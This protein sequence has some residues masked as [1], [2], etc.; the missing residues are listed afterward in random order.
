MKNIGVSLFSFLKLISEKQKL[1]HF[2][3]KIGKGF[4]HKN[5][6]YIHHSLLQEHEHAFFILHREQL[7]MM[8][9]FII[10]LEFALFFNLHRTITFFLGSIICIYFFDLLFNLFLVIRS[11]A[12]TPEIEV[13]QQEINEYLAIWPRYT[14]L[15]PLYKETAVLNQFITAIKHI[16][17]PKT[18]LQVLLLLEEDDTES[19]VILQKMKLPTYFETVIVPHSF[20][21]TKPKAMNYGLRHVTGEFIAIYDAED[22]PDPQQLKKVIIAFGKLK[23]DTVCIQAKLNFYNAHQNLLTR[24]FT[25][26]YS[27]WFDLILPGLQSIHAPIPLG[28]TSNH[29]K[30]KDLIEMG[31]WDSFNVTEDADLGMRLVQNG[32]KTAMLN[33]T[34]YEEANSNVGNWFHQRTRWIKGY[35]QT[36]LVHTRDPKEHV[37]TTG[38][39][40]F[41]IFNLIIGGKVLSALLNPFMWG[42]TLLYFLYRAHVGIFIE[43]FF[44]PYILYIGVICFF[45]GN[46]LYLFYYM[47]GVSKRGQ[48]ELIKY[49]FLVPLYWVFMSLAAWRAVYTLIAEP[50]YWSKTIHGLHLAKKI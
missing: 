34:T 45:F 29:F 32:G 17:Y 18:R 23:T 42:L 8:L 25:A 14:I 27:L 24:V 38:R 40:T 30:K 21:K 11:F 44:P 46:F 28:G 7:N 1:L 39:K 47:L 16:D 33:S 31:A 15:C 13:T 50:H 26:E 19:L 12:F 36:Y 9:L 35:I 2:E 43:S 48:D 22:I 20:P 5:D 49:V 37:A 3:N 4:L 41:L 10:M 6:E